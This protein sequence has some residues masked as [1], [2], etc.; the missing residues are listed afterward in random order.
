MANPPNRVYVW[1]FEQWWS[2]HPGDWLRVCAERGF[3]SLDDLGEMVLPP[4]S[5]VWNA[6]SKRSR[7]ITAKPGTFASIMPCDYKAYDWD[8]ERSRL[9]DWIQDKGFDIAA[10]RVEYNIPYLKFGECEFY[11]TQRQLVV[12]VAEMI[13]NTHGSIT[14]GKDLLYLFRSEHPTEINA[15]LAAEQIFELFWGDSPD[16]SDDELEI[17]NEP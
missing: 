12:Q 2:V 9:I 3:S 13:Y 4:Y 10:L 17:G 11:M 16:Y 7:E 5:K 14:E 6:N 1:Q 8:N 15:L